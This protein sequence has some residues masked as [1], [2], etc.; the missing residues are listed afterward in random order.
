MKYS[1]LTPDALERALSLR[2]L[3]DPMYGPHAMQ[4]IIEVIHQALAKRWQCG[5]LLH[6]ANPVVCVEDNY[7]RLGYPP[8]GAARDARYTRYV[9][10][11]MMLRSHSSAMIPGLLRT[12]A[13]DP[14]HD[15]LLVCPGLVYRRDTIDRLHTGEPHQLDLWRVI[16][17]NIAIKDLVDMIS[18]IVKAALPGY[19]YRTTDAQHPYTTNGLQID[20]YNGNQWIEIGECGLASPN[21][22]QSAGLK[23]VTGLAMGLGLDRILMIRKGIDDIRLLRSQDPRVCQQMLDLNPY[24]PVS[25]QP[26]IRRDLSV[27]VE[28]DITPEELGDQIRQAIPEHVV[29]LESVE[30]L[31]ETPYNEL[32]IAA[33]ARMGMRQEQKNVLLRLVIRDPVVTL[34]STE[35]NHIR[36]LVYRTL[37]KGNRME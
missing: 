11:N 28:E 3:T 21:V 23:H 14:P 34:T 5:R 2:D 37:H 18:T 25:N 17:H 27:A 22:L 7:D 30:I 19:E 12:L 20:V 29:K 4:Q 1:K 6:H 31:S 16:S 8:D 24:V 9:T 10:A 15:V 13:I 36:D 32:P 26:A 33:H 35:A